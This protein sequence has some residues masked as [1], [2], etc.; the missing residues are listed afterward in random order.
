MQT[1]KTDQI[2]QA[3]PRLRWAHMPFC[4]FCREAAQLCKYIMKPIS[5]YMYVIHVTMYCP[6][7]QT[8]RF[9]LVGTANIVTWMSQLMRLWYLS[10]RQPAKTQA[11]LRI[12]AVSPEP[13]LFALIKY[14]NRQRVRP[15]IRHLAPLNGCAYVFEEWVYGGQKVPLSHESAQIRLEGYNKSIFYVSI[16]DKATTCYSKQQVRER[17][18]T[19]I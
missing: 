1:A 3:D 16:I 15:K 17:T 5:Y 12:R 4:W 19:K 10:H 11:S 8:G 7:N 18:S 14:G 6:G 2:A 9:C 13:S